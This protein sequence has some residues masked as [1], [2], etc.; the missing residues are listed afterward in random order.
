MEI[1]IPHQF[2][3]RWYQLE[4]LKSPKRF[5][6]AV[7]HRRAGKSKMAFNDQVTKALTKQ[8][9]YYYF[10][11]TYKQAKQVIWDSIVRQHIPH[12]VVKKLNESELAIY[13]VN[14]SIQRIVGCEDPDKHRGINPTDAVFDEYSE[15]SE[16]IWTAIIQPV[17]R[18]NMGTASFIFTPKGKNHAWRLLQTAKDDSDW[19]WS[20]KSV[21]DTKAISPDELEKARKNT[22]Q[23]FFEQEY[24]CSFLDNAGAFFRRIRQNLWEG[25]LEPE[26]GFSYQLGVDLAKYQDWTVL[27]PFSL[28]DFKIGLQDRFQQVD[29]NLQKAR[30]E[31]LARRY[32]TARVIIDSTGV[33]D[34]ITE[35]LERQGLAI[36]PFKFTEISK[37]Q[38]L[39]NLALL[40]EQDRITLPDDEGLLS[41]LEATRFEMSDNGKVKVVT[42]Q[43]ITD[44]RVMSLALA[45]WGASKPINK[46]VTEQEFKLYSNNYN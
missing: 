27:T 1:T 29:W 38:L 19:F 30:I 46:V 45:V 17:L 26:Y 12:Q 33:G 42:P 15:M 6:I 4:Y 18:E 8:G 31:A 24:M 39:D 22:P 10:L 5:K 32:N 2:D 9:I 43:G 23:A 41:E 20:V 34:P 21:D 25:N 28:N 44:D 35:D 13:Y 36:E 7:F 11:P 16:E 14:G 3:P 40:L 37:R